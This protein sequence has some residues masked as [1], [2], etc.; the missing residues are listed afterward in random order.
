L[1]A[2]SQILMFKFANFCGFS[3]SALCDVFVVVV[4]VKNVGNLADIQYLLQGSLMHVQ[5]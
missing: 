4:V 5:Y 1:Y 2:G 3:I